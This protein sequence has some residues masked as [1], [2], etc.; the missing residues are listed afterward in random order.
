LCFLWAEISQSGKWLAADCKNWGRL[1]AETGSFLCALKTA[2]WTP[3]NFSGKAAGQVNNMCSSVPNVSKPVLMPS[4]IWSH[5]YLEEHIHGCKYMIC[6]ATRVHLW[7]W[8][9]SEKERQVVLYSVPSIFL[10]FCSCIVTQLC[11]LN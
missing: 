6:K 3:G 2:F 7:I 10:C 5:R 11:N 1:L 8:Y 9:I 4:V